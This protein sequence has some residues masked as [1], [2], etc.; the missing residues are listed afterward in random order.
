MLERFFEKNEEQKSEEFLKELLQ[1]ECQDTLLNHMFWQFWRNLSTNV[2][3]NLW[4]VSTHGGA[5]VMSIP[6]FLKKK[7]LC[8]ILE[9]SLEME[10]VLEILEKHFRMNLCLIFGKNLC[11]CV[12]LIGV[13][14]LWDMK[15]NGSEHWKTFERS[16][17]F[18][19]S[20]SHFPA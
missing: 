5:S 8:E 3:R 17:F 18:L 15:R 19:F 16:V 1:K 13:R 14:L 12:V 11:S 6:D 20:T 7:P 2:W 9:K 4:M 10:K